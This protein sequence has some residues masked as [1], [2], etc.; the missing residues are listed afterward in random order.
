MN[1]IGE[2]KPEGV[3]LAHPG[4]QYS[5]HLARELA[6]R[7]KLSAF[8][9]SS[10]VISAES[11]LDRS[12]FRLAKMFGREREW[13]NHRLSGVHIGRIH[14]YPALELISAFDL[15]RGKPA[16]SVFRKRN[17]RFQQRIPDSMLA[18][19][20]TT[21]GF[22]T[23]SH[24]L[25][26]RT[27]KLGRK[28]ILDRSIAYEPGLNGVFEKLHN[29]FP[30]WHDAKEVKSNADFEIE[31]REHE[32]ADLIAVPSRFVANSLIARGVSE[33]KIRINPFGTELRLF[34]P[35]QDTPPIS[36]M[37]FLFVGALTARKGLPLLLQA[38]KKLA[39]QKTELWIA[40]HGTVPEVS[41]VDVPASVKWLGQ[42]SRNKLRDAF[43][44]VHVFIC[45]SYFEGLAQVQLEAAASGLPVIGTSASGAAEV[46]EDGKTGYVVEPG[47]LGEL[48]DRIERFLSRTQ[49]VSEMRSE[50]IRRR[51]GLAWSFYGDRWG[52]ILQ[53]L[54]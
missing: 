5:F 41:L 27:M 17:D 14:S 24:I 35:G 52:N 26:E 42:I 51:N 2:R 31:D 10:F 46:I 21:I 15:K 30:E 33:Q 16:I 54:S 37:V 28:F 45:P 3:L 38:W 50:A 4:T 29:E 9:T 25:A 18:Q 6:S 49:L 36:P 34:Q 8:C 44:R 32:L 22:D 40:G 43:Q 7:D 47:S 11:K 20:K 1:T 19:A 12:L 13:Q 48:I 39:P 53:E 23:S